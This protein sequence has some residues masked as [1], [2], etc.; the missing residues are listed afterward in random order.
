[1]SLAP[2]KTRPTASADAVQALSR[3]VFRPWDSQIV[4]TAVRFDLAD[5]LAD[6]PR[7]SADLA[8]DLGADPAT[9]DRFLRSCAV[10]GL[11]ETVGPDGFALTALGQVLESNNGV[12]RSMVLMN[13]THGMWSRMARLH[14]TVLTGQPVVDDAGEDL[15]GYYAR[16]PHER[17]WHADAMAG[18]SVDAG[19][20]IAA[21]YDFTPYSTI[22]DVGGSLGVLLSRILAAAPHAKGVV[23]DLPAI[24][25]RA[26]RTPPA[27]AVGG[28][29]DFTEGSF[30]TDRLPPADLYLIKQV[31]CDW[32]DDDAARILANCF[33][34]APSG[35]R[36]VVVEW[37]RPA[38][39]EPS[40]LDLM[41]LCL[42]VV[43]GGRARTESDFV[44]LI[45][46]AGYQYESCVTVPST[47][48]P[49]PWNLLQAIRP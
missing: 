17:G 20:N 45:E 34:S 29:L 28:R 35:S 40:S 12:F 47:V 11:V 22:V 46:G 16:S 23:F 13:T 14:E 18:L 38:G 44:R 1:M 9:F 7:T 41:S 39:P 10:L 6:G 48:S 49:R 42:Q 8:A 21:H 27:G 33:R 15:Y 4:A 2:E 43:T 24:V 19:Q 36:L 3:I 26:R 25:A 30:F 32:G 31:L 5:R 37:V